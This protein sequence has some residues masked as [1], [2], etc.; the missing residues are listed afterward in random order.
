MKGVGN[1]HLRHKHPMNLKASWKIYWWVERCYYW[2]I[3]YHKRKC[4]ST[5]RMRC[6]CR[7]LLK[8]VRES[9]TSFCRK[10]LIF[11]SLKAT[12]GVILR[13]TLKC[14]Q[15]HCFL[16]S[17]SCTV[18]Q[19]TA[20]VLCIWHSFVKRIY[21]FMNNFSLMLRS[22]TVFAALCCWCYRITL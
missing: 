11:L 19:V 3:S 9:P 8:A 17:V 22:V 6:K 16:F 4:C 12:F 10:L 1:Y 18:K 5:D 7:L 20:F 2:E 13:N 14:F 15:H 21:E